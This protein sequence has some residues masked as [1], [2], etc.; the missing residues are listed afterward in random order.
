MRVVFHQSPIY[1]KPGWCF[2]YLQN[3]KVKGN[4][5]VITLMVIKIRWFTG[6]DLVSAKKKKKGPRDCIIKDASSYKQQK[7]QLKLAETMKK[8]YWLK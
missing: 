8:I 6:K 5:K 4:Y 7:K 3:T 2:I 1:L